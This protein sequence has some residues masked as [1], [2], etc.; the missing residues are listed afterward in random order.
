M[1]ALAIGLL[2]C[3]PDP[4]EE[5][6]AD[7]VVRP[8]G[9]VAADEPFDTKGLRP[10]PLPEAPVTAR[11]RLSPT[12]LVDKHGTPTL[13]LDAVGVE[14]EVTRALSDRVWITC[15]GCRTPVEAWLLRQGVWHGTEAGAGPQDGLLAWV[16]ATE[17]PDVARHGFVE[18]AGVWIAPPWHD[19]GG[20]AG[21]V[22][23][24]VA[25]DDG[26]AIEEAA[27]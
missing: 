19:E 16:S 12:T 11:T 7:G 22:L 14:V 21:D 2:G 20:Y 10:V 15:T 27:P 4:L 24:I 26:F 8:E 17:L 3:A 6:P 25:T 18:S 5:G 23:R 9:H 1:F 13:V